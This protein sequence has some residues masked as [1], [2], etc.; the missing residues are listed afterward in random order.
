MGKGKKD[1]EGCSPSDTGEV[2]FAFPGAIEESGNNLGQLLMVLG[3]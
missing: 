1:K 3:V 2:A